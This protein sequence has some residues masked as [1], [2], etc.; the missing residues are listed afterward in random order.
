MDFQDVFSKMH[1][2]FA[3]QGFQKSH[4][5]LSAM[6]NKKLAQNQQVLK[7]SKGLDTSEL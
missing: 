6:R 7:V 1:I 3:F 4:H 2:A 5:E